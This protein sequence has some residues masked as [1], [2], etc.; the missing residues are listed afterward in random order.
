MAYRMPD[1][2]SSGSHH[3]E[4]TLTHALPSVLAGIN[5]PIRGKSV[6][7]LIKFGTAE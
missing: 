6:A 4:M 1:A 2:T 3:S 7:Q 5:L